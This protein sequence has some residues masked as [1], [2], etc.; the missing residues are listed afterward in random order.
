MIKLPKKSV[1]IIDKNLKMN[2]FYNKLNVSNNAKIKLTQADKNYTSKFNDKKIEIN[3]SE[4]DE[5]NLRSVNL[6]HAMNIEHVCEKRKISNLGYFPMKMTSLNLLKKMRMKTHVNILGKPQ[7]EK[8]VSDHSYAKMD[9]N[10]SIMTH[11]TSPEYAAIY[12]QRQN[13]NINNLYHLNSEL[14][15]ELTNFMLS[16]TLEHPVKIIYQ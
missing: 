5:S 15:E 9:Q 4:N 10:K 7:T 13:I 8:W 3:T 6:Y 2:L 16:E 11:V 12:I 1:G 14:S